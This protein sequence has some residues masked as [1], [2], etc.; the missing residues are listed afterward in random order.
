MRPAV[1]VVCPDE[2]TSLKVLAAARPAAERISDTVV[3][4]WNVKGTAAV[5][6]KLSAQGVFLEK[7]A[8]THH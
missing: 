3:A 4:L 2:E 1:L 5:M 7:P 8:D 6:R